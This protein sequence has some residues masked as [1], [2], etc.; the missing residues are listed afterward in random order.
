MTNL[1]DLIKFEN[2]NSSLDFKA[3]QY[4]KEQ[5]EA[6]LKDVISMANANVDGDCYVIVG[7]KYL[8]DGERTIEGIPKK[9]FIDESTY[10][11]LANENIEPEISIKYFSYKVENKSVGVF[12]IS[13]RNDKPY[14]MKKDFRS[15]KKGDSFIRKGSHQ[16]RLSRRDLDLILEK[17]NSQSGFEGK[18]SIYIEGHEP[19]EIVEFPIVTEQILYELPSRVADRKIKRLIEEKRRKINKTNF[20][21]LPMPVA[22]ELILGRQLQRIAGLESKLGDFPKSLAE[23]DALSL[24]DISGVMLGGSLPYEKRSI[25]QL[26][27]NLKK[28]QKTY[29]EDDLYYI[30]EQSANKLNFKILNEGDKYIEDASIRI[31]IEN[32]DGLTIPD[33]IYS[34]PE[35]STYG[36]PMSHLAWE[37]IGYPNVKYID[38]KVVITHFLKGDVRHN[39]P[40]VA[41][42]VPIRIIF[43]PKLEGQTIEIMCELHGKNLKIP[44]KKKIKIKAV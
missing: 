35:R 12:Q 13:D 3:I 5:Y 36:L 30:N 38:S 44:L 10:Q 37:G 6:F 7:V 32:V 8:S 9:E 31:E 24:S 33:H 2:E 16:P 34:K 14:M 39:I 18:V 29:A 26:E 40:S 19:D 43:S 17:K 28:L 42:E 21:D 11:Q 25:E 15:L 23:E 41:F 22:E 27:S 1:D 20:T 4:K